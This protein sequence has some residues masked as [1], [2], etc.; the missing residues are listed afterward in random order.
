MRI[1][2]RWI[3]VAL[4]LTACARGERKDVRDSA[5]DTTAAQDAPPAA[6][7]GAS[8]GRRTILFVGTSLTAGYGLPDPDEAYPALIQQRIDSLGLNYDVINAGV[9]GETS[10]GAL[11]RIDWLMRE[12]VNVFVLETGANDG[13]RGLNSDSLRS[14]IQQIFDRVRAAHP[15]ARLVLA[16]MEAPP[17]LGPRYTTAFR[18]IFPELARKNGATLIPFLLAGV[19][20]VD[21]LN[22]PDGI[23]PN[24]RG[25]KVVAE[26]VWKV[27]GPMVEGGRP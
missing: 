6:R 26:N 5:R 8:A 20:G 7:A 27:L 18:E 3:V 22:Q 21:S 1:G 24:V 19:A 12:P 9:S 23:H 25:A 2:F 14:N 15:D 4:A 17:N 10:T 11:K 13:L 16:G